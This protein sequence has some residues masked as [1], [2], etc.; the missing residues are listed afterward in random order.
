MDTQ[1]ELINK[2][3]SL[4]VKAAEKKY[5]DNLTE[6]KNLAYNND[7]MLYTMEWRSTIMLSRAHM[8]SEFQEMLQRIAEYEKGEIGFNTVIGM[9]KFLRSI[10][11][12]KASRLSHVLSSVATNEGFNMSNKIKLQVFLT[13]CDEDVMVMIDEMVSEVN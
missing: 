4:I 6:I 7:M 11:A 5:Q 9:F 1:K 10:Y 2:I 12:K 8:Y 13:I 3:K